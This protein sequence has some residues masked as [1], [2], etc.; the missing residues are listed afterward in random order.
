MINNHFI[1][2]IFN[3]SILWLTAVLE[4]EQNQKRI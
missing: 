4:S 1:I 2:L 3:Q